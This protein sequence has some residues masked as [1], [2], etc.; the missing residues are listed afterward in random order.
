LNHQ[1][2]K[3]D[4][5][6]RSFLSFAATQCAGYSPLYERLA[7]GIAQDESL[8]ELVRSAPPAQQRPTLFFAAVHELVVQERT[9]PLAAYYAS[10]TSQVASGDPL[11]AFRSFC[12]VHRE[13]ILDR[14][15]S[16]GTQT[17]DV[18]RCAALII[19]LHHV[20]DR[21]G[22]PL[23]LVE[24]GASAGLLLLFDR[25]RITIGGR[26]L[27]PEASLVDIRVDADKSAESLAP[28]KMPSVADRVGVDLAPV[29]LGDAGQV[30]WLEAFVWPE[31]HSDRVRLKAATVIAQRSPP[32]V[33]EGD[34]VAMLP[35]L[36]GN[37]D[38]TCVPV[39]FHSTLFTYL[40]AAQR[41]S[42]AQC[43]E[44]VGSRR[45]LCWL[46]MEAPGFLTGTQPAFHI[47][48]AIA[49]QNSQFVLAARWWRNAVPQSSILAQVD[50][51]GRSIR[52]L[53]HPE[54]AGSSG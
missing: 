47:P 53:Y 22:K 36:L 19:A 27:G 9:H 30:R 4:K 37:I 45:D 52:G 28:L 39:V 14:M 3:T 11:P 33:L 21:V 34:A 35:T 12:S 7:T 29:D 38:E 16:G 44:S 10:V 32:H 51:Y 20:Q 6:A 17:N 40:D 50:A 26:V 8:L 49:A 54:R 41:Q 31:A 5:L 18:R 42:V 1:L 13:Q 24:I 48:S 23:V 15:T 46:P 43:M 2:V 25:Y